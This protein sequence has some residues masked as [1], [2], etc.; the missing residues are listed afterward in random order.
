VLLFGMERGARAAQSKVRPM[1]HDDRQLCHMRCSFGS[2]VRY[3]H[4]TV[5]LVVNVATFS[6]PGAR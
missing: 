2:S 1:C 5:P 4:L 3:S 6:T